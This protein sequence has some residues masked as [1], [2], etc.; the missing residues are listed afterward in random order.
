MLCGSVWSYCEEYQKRE[1]AKDN[2]YATQLYEINIVYLLIKS[3]HLH[4]INSINKYLIS[5]G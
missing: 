2:I 3:D 1:T 4:I 5:K